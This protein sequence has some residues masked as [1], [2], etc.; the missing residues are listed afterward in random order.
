MSSSQ[1]L[2]SH[3]GLNFVDGSTRFSNICGQIMAVTTE[4]QAEKPVR[5]AGSFSHLYI[6]IPSNTATVTS[7]VTLRKSR[8][9]TALTVSI[10]S[11][12]TGTFQDTTNTVAFAATDEADWG[13]VVPAEVGT[14]NL[15]PSIIAA[16]F[17]P[18][19]TTDTVTFLSVASSG[20]S[21]ASTT[22]Y[23]SP[24]GDNNG[25]ATEA[26]EKWRVRT[27]QVASDFTALVNTNGRTTNTTITTR[28]NGADGSMTFTYT[29]TQTGAKED[30]VNTDSLAA[31]DDFNYSITTGSGTGTITFQ[32]IG[33]S[34][35][36]TNDV[37]TLLVGG[38]GG[39]G[40]NFNSTQYIP[41]AGRLFHPTIG[42]EV[43]AQFLSQFDFTAKELGVYVSAN[44]IATSDTVVTVRDNGVDSSLTVSYTAGQTGLKNDS[45]NTS[46]ITGGT[47]ELNYKV[48][49][50]NTSGTFTL[51]WISVLGEVGAAAASSI[52]T[53]NGLQKAA[54]K[55]WN[56]VAIENMK[57]LNGLA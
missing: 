48:V 45:V 27:T 46:A 18:D 52:K 44:T 24:N 25:Q 56:G 53:I 11:D 8:A 12:Q 4:S 43:A 22:V 50:P 23:M 35:I 6:H 2:A 1:V 54:T 39:Y 3:P 32:Q 14:N 31:G 13:V 33:C 9:D 55:V 5:D 30:T 37:F 20:Y 57:T 28:K 38:Q 29:S 16:K 10:G 42:T 49:T 47:D 21:V 34:L 51:R 41:C 17:T 40:I 19:T 7:T 36:S 26:D 15:T